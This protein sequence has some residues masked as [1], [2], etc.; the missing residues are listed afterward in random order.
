MTAIITDK[1]KKKL[2][3]DIFDDALDSATYY[4]IGIGRSEDW[5]S[6]DTAPT[7]VNRDRDE[8]LFRYSLQSIIA[9]NTYS[10]VIPRYNWSSGSVYNQYNDNVSGQP[11]VSY[12]IVTDE[13]KVYLCVRQGKDSNG[14]A[15]VSTVKPTHTDI[16]LDPETDGYIWKYLYTVTTADANNYLTANFFPVKLA[17]SSGPLDADFNQYVVQQSAIPRQIVGYRVT[18][19]G[20]GFTSDPAVTVVGNGSGAHAR[21]IVTSTGTIGAIEVDDSAGGFPHGTNYTNAN[22]VISGGGG[23]GATAVP[24]FG[25]PTGLGADPRDDLRSTAIMFNVKPS[26]IVNGDF[27][28]GNDFRQIGLIKNPTLVDSD[29]LFVD[30]QGRGLKMM[31]ISSATGDFAED[32][33]VVGGSSTARAIIDYYNDSSQIWYH[34]T[35]DTGFVSFTDGENITTSS[36]SATA[37]SANVAPEFDIHSGDVLYIDNRSQSITRA[38]GQTEDIKII[39]QL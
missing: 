21:A 10:F 24:I 5:D 27:V 17:D 12:Y 16:S 8:R 9:A 29:E 31:N 37:D 30:L 28:V 11:A 7:P 2:I 22:I 33:I 15:V 23:S 18:A 19:A 26:G 35:E 38:V 25:P 36:A 20:T 39:I 1:I 14:S 6:S 32:D 4:Y 34:Q 3:Q 13:N